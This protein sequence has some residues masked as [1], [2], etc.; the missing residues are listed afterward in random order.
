MKLKFKAQPYQ[1]NAIESVVD[2]FAGQQ[3]I[4]KLILVFRDSSSLSDFTTF[5]NKGAGVPAP[6]TYRKRAGWNARTS[7]H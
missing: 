1:I 3:M 7:R 4:S 5:N 2:C 6:A